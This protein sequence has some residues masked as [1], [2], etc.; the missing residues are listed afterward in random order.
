MTTNKKIALITGGNKGLGFEIARQLGQQNITVLITSRDKKKGE[1][2]INE[3]KKE[4]ID[5]H[6]VTMDVTDE[7]SIH[8]ARLSVEKEFGI[9]DILINNAGIGIDV[10][11]AA[12]EVPLE[13]I[14]QTYDTNVFGAIATI[15]QFLPL[16]KK[17]TAGRIVNVSS[18]L[19][20][21]TLNADPHYI[22]YAH[23]PLGYNTS[24]AALNA[25]T[26]MFAHELR[27]TP[28]KINSADPGFCA[29]DLNGNSG[30]RN[31]SQGASIS[32]KLATLPDDGPTGG[33]FDDN[34]RVNW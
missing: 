26:V 1:E 32:V 18:G 8:Q 33:F 31:R 16:L 19:G 13:I 27:L 11:I 34:G 9:L 25:V 30:P 10:G 2:A 22:Y 24:K 14:K 15:Q 3:L 4:S 29:T 6:L 21:I 7:T 28:I 20:S 12:S 5:A 23:K 17:S